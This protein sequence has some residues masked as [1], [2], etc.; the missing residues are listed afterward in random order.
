MVTV[1][2]DGREGR[3]KN[4]CGLAAIGDQ[5]RTSSIEIEI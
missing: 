1:I 4:I 3:A 5:W 2:V